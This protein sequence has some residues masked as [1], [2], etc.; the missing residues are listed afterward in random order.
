MK[1]SSLWRLGS[2]LCVA[3]AIAPTMAAEQ[4]LT[5]YQFKPDGIYPVNTGLGIT[6]QI[7]LSPNEKVLDYSTGLSG[8]WDLTRR[9]NVFYLKPKNVDVDTNMMVRT[10]THSYIFELRAVATDWKTLAQARRDG[11]QYKIAFNYPADTSFANEK[12]KQLQ[13]AAQDMKRVTLELGGKS[14]LI[15]RADADVAQ[16]VT[17]AVGGAFANAGQMCSATA[18]IL[19]HDDVYRKFMAAFETAVRAL[20]VAPPDHGGACEAPSEVL[21][22]LGVQDQ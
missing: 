5:R 17:L 2:T 9:E 20:V 22:F 13:A 11:V 16:A 19:V 8:G 14:A 6:T 18:R 4:V 15:V 12:K 3:A 7:E 21:I 10:A 1:R